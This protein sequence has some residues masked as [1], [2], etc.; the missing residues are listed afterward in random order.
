MV[1]L[2]FLAS[3]SMSASP[4]KLPISPCTARLALVG[5]LVYAIP[6]IYASARLRPNPLRFP[7]PIRA[8]RSQHS[9]G[10]FRRRETIILLPDQSITLAGSLFPD[11]ASVLTM[12]AGDRL[13]AS[14][15]FR[16]VGPNA[17]A[18]KLQSNA[19]RVFMQSSLWMWR[20]AG[21]E[22]DLLFSRRLIF[23]RMC[24]TP[25]YPNGFGVTGRREGTW[26]TRR[27]SSRIAVSVPPH[28]Q[29]LSSIST[30]GVSMS[31]CVDQ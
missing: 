20:E 5:R 6:H 12:D 2:V 9:P 15:D 30:L 11:C 3:A 4:R 18:A 10:R 14:A 1:A 26:N 19:L 29:P 24:S 8:W 22:P 31:S 21:L 23:A 7:G 28:R 17:N 27:S 25:L 16:I 13:L